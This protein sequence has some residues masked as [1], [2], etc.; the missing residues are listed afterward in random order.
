MNNE[1][2]RFK[3]NL[4]KANRKAVVLRSF[5]F[6]KVKEVLEMIKNELE[7]EIPKA[8]EKNATFIYFQMHFLNDWVA[9]TN[10]PTPYFDILNFKYYTSSL[11]GDDNNLKLVKTYKI[12][13]S[14]YESTIEN[15]NKLIEISNKLIEKNLSIIK[16]VNE[17]EKQDLLK[18]KYDSEI[19]LIKSLIKEFSIKNETNTLNLLSN[20]NHIEGIY[21]FVV[22]LDKIDEMEDYIIQLQNNSPKEYFN[23]IEIEIFDLDNNKYKTKGKNIKEI[24]N[25]EKIIDIVK[26]NRIKKTKLSYIDIEDYSPEFN[27]IKDIPPIGIIDSAP[28][29]NFAKTYSEVVEIIDLGIEI[30]GISW[31]SKPDFTE[32]LY[33]HGEVV[34]SLFI[35][36]PKLNSYDD[37]C[38]QLKA[39][40]FP[41]ITKGIIPKDVY[42]RIEYT[43]L[44]TDLKIYL[45]NTSIGVENDLRISISD[46]GKFLDNLTK[47]VKEEQEREIKFIVC[48]TNDNN[49]NNDFTNIESS[50]ISKTNY[51]LG[52]ADS[53]ESFTVNSV[54]S[55]SDEIPSSYSR[56]GITRFVTLKPDVS[57]FGGDNRSTKLLYS[58]NNGKIILI[59]NGG[60]SFSTPLL[61]RLYVFLFY[62][63]KFSFEGVEALLIN[64]SIRNQY[65]KNR[66]PN[67]IHG[68]GVPSNHI[69][70]ILNTN[71]ETYLLYFDHTSTQWIEYEQEFPLFYGE[72]NRNNNN[73]IVTVVS[74]S[75]IE[76]EYGVEAIRN[77]ITATIVSMDKKIKSNE[78][79]N[80]TYFDGIEYIETEKNFL[81]EKE[82]IKFLGKW[83]NRHSIQ[84]IAQED[85]KTKLKEGSNSIK[86]NF[87]RNSRELGDVKDDIYFACVISI[88]S[89]S[90]SINFEEYDNALKERNWERVQ[91]KE[92]EQEKDKY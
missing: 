23:E 32:G 70:N 63:Y 52:P 18:E 26:Q 45:I 75:K 28:T 43:V 30:E 61:A 39:I 56:K 20:L 46:F 55:F 37:G 66:I 90:G 29:K 82:I 50:I 86:I 74:N 57:F 34:T 36:G 77:S 16:L 41:L 24:N 11:Y 62:E 53:L 40:L 33:S 25:N 91:I 80:I 22:P 72:Q 42:S 68:N 2:R 1:I 89:K 58:Q 51:I 87:K 35:E 8:I 6:K 76:H 71:D 64:N 4:L 78:K 31:L 13:I 17:K 48:G 7:R 44:N 19:K 88:I 15:I 47:K 5:Y 60:T 14:L 85:K 79:M 69:N 65:S 92:Q 81:N 3:N 10:D 67:V 27:D 49:S 73:I 21:N 59:P 54:D 38:G 84:V 83:K 12:E 9:K